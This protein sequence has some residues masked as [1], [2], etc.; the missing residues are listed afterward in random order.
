MSESDDIRKLQELR[1]RGLLTESDVWQIRLQNELERLDREWETERKWYLL[2]GR[3]GSLHV[4]TKG[5]IVLP[6]LFFGLQG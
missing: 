4:P 2:R 5:W 1:D 6:L 3:R